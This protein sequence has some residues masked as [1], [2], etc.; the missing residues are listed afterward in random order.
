M[1]SKCGAGKDSSESHGLKG[2]QELIPKEINPEYSLAGLILKLKLQ[3]FGHLM[4][5]ANSLEA[6]AWCWE[7]LRAGEGGWQ[8]EMVTDSMDMTLSKLQGTVK[9]REAWH[10]PVHGVTKSQTGISDWT[11]TTKPSATARD[12][13]CFQF[14]TKKNKATVSSLTHTFY[15]YPWF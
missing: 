9:N 12:S 15:W 6:P 11:T 4:W 3:Y 10:A 14:P 7:R 13:G 2:D 5:R 8:D 1:I